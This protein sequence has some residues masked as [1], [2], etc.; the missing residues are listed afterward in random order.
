MF[1]VIA[2]VI[3]IIVIIIMMMIIMIT[4]TIFVCSYFGSSGHLWSYIYSAAPG[5]MSSSRKNSDVPQL[6]GSASERIKRKSSDV[7]LLEDTASDS[8]YLKAKRRGNSSVQQP[9]DQQDSSTDSGVQQPTH[10]P[11]RILFADAGCIQSHLKKILIKDTREHLQT[12]ELLK[13]A[14]DAK[15]SIIIGADFPEDTPPDMWHMSS[16]I[17]H[18]GDRHPTSWHV[19]FQKETWSVKDFFSAPMS[20]V[21]PRFLLNPFLQSRE[22]AMLHLR[23]HHGHEFAV[24]FVKILKGAAAAVNTLRLGLSERQAVVDAVFTFLT[25]TRN[26]PAIVAGDFGVGLPTLHAFIRSE[27][28]ENKVHTFCIAS[29][30]FHT[31]FYSGQH[32]HQCASISTNSSRMLLHEVDIHSGDQYPTS[33]HIHQR[34]RLQ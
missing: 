14:M 20:D 11:V 6:A 33:G 17:C 9:A 16:L 7:P 27:A 24:M 19:W 26:C 12:D 23:H 31:L 34:L 30:T 4:I 1:V 18:T 2:L 8:N 28:L 10:L 13:T 21:H 3:A 5:L 32:L 25:K 29:Q 15:A 22:C